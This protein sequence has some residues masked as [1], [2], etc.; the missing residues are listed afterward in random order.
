M[1]KRLAALFDVA[2]GMQAREGVGGAYK[3]ETKSMQMLKRHPKG[4]KNLSVI[5]A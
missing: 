4:R 2:M 3:K 1:A 5:K